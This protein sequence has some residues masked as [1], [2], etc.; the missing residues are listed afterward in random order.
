M[1][2][3]TDNKHTHLID[4]VAFVNAVIGAIA[5]YPQLYALLRLREHGE[6]L[7]VISFALIF[8]NSIIWFWYG[9]HRKVIPLVISSFLNAVAA[10][11]I[12]FLIF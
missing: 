2:I 8:S 5:L 7:S 10:G 1:D 4:K 12:L 6:E 11:A 9:I 3:H